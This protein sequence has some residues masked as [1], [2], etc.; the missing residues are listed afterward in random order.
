MTDVLTSRDDAEASQVADGDSALPRRRK[1]IIAVVI[2]GLLAGFGLAYLVFREPEGPSL[3][4]GEPSITEF[5]LPAAGGGAATTPDTAPPVVVDE[6]VS[7]RAALEQFLTAEVARSYDVSFAL[8]DRKTRET[9]GPVAAWQNGRAN[10]LVPETFK[11]LSEKPGDEG[12]EVTITATRT[13]SISVQTGL[14]PSKSTEIWRV[15]DDGGWRVVR[16]RPTDVQPV[17]PSDDQASALA[18]A[19]LERTAECDV[20]GAVALQLSANLLGSPALRDNTCKTK[21]TW[22]AGKAFPVSELPNSTVLVSAYGPGVG[23]WARAVPVTGAGR[24]TIV[25]APLGDEWRVMGVL[26]QGSPRP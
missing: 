10:R 14:V 12:V 24:Y 1:L 15:V 9:D 4:A 7:A 23:R 16:G 3:F 26:P 22:T 8:L 21:G 17:L 19:W 11:I 13:P 25:L 18:A 6:P 20:D 2:G 5:D